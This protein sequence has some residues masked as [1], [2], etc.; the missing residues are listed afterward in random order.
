MNELR[1]INLIFK[2]LALNNLI[3]LRKINKD[4]C[5]LIERLLG[6]NELLFN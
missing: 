4:F 5:L 1:W 3:K 2:Y 6:I